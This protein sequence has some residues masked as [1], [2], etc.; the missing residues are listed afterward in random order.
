MEPTSSTIVSQFIIDCARLERFTRPLIFGLNGPQGSG[1]TTVAL[2]AIKYAAQHGLH[3]IA[4]SIDDFYLTYAQQAQ[5]AAKHL[6][7]PYLQQR[8]YPG[9][10]DIGLGTAT[11]EQLSKINTTRESVQIPRYDKSCHNGQGD[12]LPQ[13]QWT[14]VQPPLDFVIFEGWCVGFTPVTNQSIQDSSLEQINDLLKDYTQWYNLFTGFIQLKADDT[15][16]TVAWRIQAE[17]K[18]RAMGVPAMND[19]AIRSYIE[20]FLPAY[21]LYMP[22][23]NYWLER[24]NL[25]TL[26]IEINR[27]RAVLDYKV[28]I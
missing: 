18:M 9:T 2:G 15:Q 20:N 12:R 19:K 26:V 5:L 3:G 24:A 13:E 17:D 4:V 21:K 16:N 27:D 8:G 1:K 10:H 28:K 25:A 7:N 11:L 23:L 22:T 6:D 14:K